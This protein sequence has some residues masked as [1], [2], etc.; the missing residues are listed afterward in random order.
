MLKCH[1]ITGLP[2]AIANHL[3]SVPQEQRFSDMVSMANTY[4]ARN[5]GTEE[6]AMLSTADSKNETTTRETR[7]CFYCGMVGHI[8][9]ECRKKKA[10]AAKNGENKQ[11]N[12]SGSAQ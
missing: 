8:Q 4:A 7:K 2:D 1:F 5:V 12:D 6:V 3:Y 10:A 11:G 9:R